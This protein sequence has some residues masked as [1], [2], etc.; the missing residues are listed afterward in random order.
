VGVDSPVFLIT[1]GARYSGVPHNVYVSPGAGQYIARCF[2]ATPLTV[3]NLLCESEIDEFQ[4]PLGVYQNVLGLQV[5]VCDALLL[6]QKF[7]YQD[8][9]GGV[10][11]GRGLVEASRSSEVAEDLA[12]RAVVELARVRCVI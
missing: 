5:P 2:P 9:L 12:A 7:E 4:V 8:N 1:S 10:E 6:V 11:L 3:F